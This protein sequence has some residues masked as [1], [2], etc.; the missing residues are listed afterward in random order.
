MDGL[1]LDDDVVSGKK[2]LNEYIKYHRI[3]ESPVFSRL[4]VG[5]LNMPQRFKPQGI[6]L[7]QNE[8]RKNIS[9]MTVSQWI[10]GKNSERKKIAMKAFLNI[11]HSKWTLKCR[12]SITHA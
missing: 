12:S 6:H 4:C 2:K 8:L 7:Q 3:Q 1:K 9:S 11:W 5:L 10:S